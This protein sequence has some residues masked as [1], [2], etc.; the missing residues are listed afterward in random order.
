MI[1]VNLNGQIYEAIFQEDASKEF[2]E[3]NSFRETV[4]LKDNDFDFYLNKKSEKIYDKFFS[5]SV[6][7]DNSTFLDNR[8]ASS[9]TSEAIALHSS[10]NFEDRILNWD[11]YHKISMKYA[12]HSLTSINRKFIFIP[13]QKNFIPLY[14]DG[15]IQFPIGKTKC[16]LKSNNKIFKDFSDEYKKLSNENLSPMKKC[17][18]HEIMSLL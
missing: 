12:R 3:R 17:V 7:I 18:F 2:L 1:E 11:L 13:H 9:I 16:K 6:I 8:V 15:M 5:K 4:I 14:Y 10:K